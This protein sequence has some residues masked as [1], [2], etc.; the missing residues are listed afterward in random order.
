MAG[1]GATG[2]GNIDSGSDSCKRDSTLCN[3]LRYFGR[4]RRKDLQRRERSLSEQ[5]VVVTGRAVTS[6]RVLK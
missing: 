1:S 4:Q 2:H 5:G 3:T 6:I